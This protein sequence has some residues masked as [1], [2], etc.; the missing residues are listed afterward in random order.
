MQKR[1]KEP[2][3]SEPPKKKKVGKALK[4]EL[5]GRTNGDPVSVRK[6]KLN[7]ALLE[8]RLLPIIKQQVEAY[9]KITHLATILSNIVA[10]FAIR[11]NRVDELPRTEG[12]MRSF[13]QA[14]IKSVRPHYGKRSEA[15]SQIILD[16]KQECWTVPALK[17]AKSIAEMLAP[18]SLELATNATNHLFV[19]FYDR[20]LRA[21]KRE[22]FTNEMFE[23]VKADMTKPTRTK[24]RNRIAEMRQ[25]DVNDVLY[26]GDDTVVLEH[27]THLSA[28]AKK[29][30]HK[31]IKSNQG[32]TMAYYHFIGCKECD[33]AEAHVAFHKE[34]GTTPN[35]YLK[36]RQF[37]LL[38]IR[39]Y[40]L[41]ALPIEA[42]GLYRMLLQAELL[43][44]DT[45]PTDF[46]QIQVEWF[47]RCFDFKRFAKLGRL[48]TNCRVTTDGTSCSLSY[49]IPGGKPRTRKTRKRAGEIVYEDRLDLSTVKRGLFTEKNCQINDVSK[50]VGGDPGC[51]SLL[52]LGKDGKFLHYGK[53]QHYD[54]C[55]YKRGQQKRDQWCNEYASEEIK[56]AITAS[57]GQSFTIG[58]D[59]KAMWKARSVLDPLLWKH[60]GTSKWRNLR[61]K[62]W[63]RKQKAYT[64]L[65]RRIRSTFGKDVIIA[66]GAAKFSV[67][68]VGDVSGPLVETA[69]E[70]SKHFRVVYTDEFRSSAGCYTCALETSSVKRRGEGKTGSVFCIR[71]CEQCCRYRNRDRNACL[72]IGEFAKL[73]LQNQSVRGNFIRGKPGSWPV[74]S[75]TPPLCR[76]VSPQ[77]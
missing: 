43:T 51:H 63:S 76:R 3:K 55:F 56:A 65:V 36:A 24:I 8:P 5:L 25:R 33:A 74:T 73:R 42:N 52:T 30:D 49:F 69:R 47:H 37:N 48:H 39:G 18:I 31:W 75:S 40:S 19:H 17:H 22:A 20:Q 32:R 53:K 14:C 62:Q 4:D 35:D 67:S 6:V 61:F 26:E 44:T 57:T 58:Q 54:A 72:N 71:R 1:K 11:N 50:I 7:K 38:P 28:N 15:V 27:R 16:A 77:R 66:M 34:H 9:A 45:K 13:M 23:N 29:V 46:T 21:L 64:D 68:R 70:L 60:Y 59:L 2:D 41:H 10:D 12:Q